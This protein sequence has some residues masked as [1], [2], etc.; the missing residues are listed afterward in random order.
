ML[1]SAALLAILATLDQTRGQANL[2]QNA[3]LQCCPNTTELELNDVQ[4]FDN[5]S[6]NAGSFKVDILLD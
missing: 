1:F 4:E 3:A 2:L 5:M 6:Y